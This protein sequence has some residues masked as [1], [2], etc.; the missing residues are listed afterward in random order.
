MSTIVVGWA[1]DAHGEAAVR[2]AVAEAGLTGAGL[3]LVNATRGDAAVDE[4]FAPEELRR[5]AE[6]LRGRGV[7][8]EVR[9]PVAL[10]VGDAV[11]EVAVEV[12]A[13]LIVLGLRRRSP[14]GKL[15]LGSVAQR[16]LLEAPCPV[17]AVKADSAVRT[18][19]GG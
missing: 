15:L 9:S 12:G 13:E 8:V 14:V 4:R 6:D 17:L 16:V 18:P 7:S 10:D 19:A 5:T 11:V 2:H 3:V 1:P